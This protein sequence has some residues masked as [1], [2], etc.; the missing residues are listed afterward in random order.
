MQRDKRERQAAGLA[1]RAHSLPQR[2][3]HAGRLA[4]RAHQRSAQRR[5]R[6]LQLEAPARA[7]KHAR[8]ISSG[9]GSALRPTALLV[10]SARDVNA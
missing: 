10:S 6:L 3:R 5:Q 1:C 9:L 2:G 7:C 4:Q 8:T